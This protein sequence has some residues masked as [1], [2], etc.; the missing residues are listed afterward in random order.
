[1]NILDLTLTL[2]L[3]APDSLKCWVLLDQAWVQMIP[4]VK[5]QN[6]IPHG[7]GSDS[8]GLGSDSDSS[9]S[10]SGS[11]PSGSDSPGSG[12]G[13]GSSGSNG[14]SWALYSASGSLFVKSGPSLGLE[15]GS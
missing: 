6:Q 5:V 13:S 3:Y 12:L 2:S 1:M 9:G 7:S 4:L 15:Q 14:S 11:G 10:G 8:S